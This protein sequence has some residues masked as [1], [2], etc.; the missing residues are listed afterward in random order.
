MKVFYIIFLLLFATSTAYAQKH[1]NN[2]Y[3]GDSAGVTFN[4]ASG[5]P[6]ALLDGQIFTLEVVLRYS[7]SSGNLLFILMV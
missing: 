2:W 4:T 7:D 3:F 1:F 5:E 6:E